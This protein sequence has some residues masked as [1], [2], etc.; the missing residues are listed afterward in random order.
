MPLVHDIV[1]P[2]APTMRV[3]SYRYLPK[4]FQTF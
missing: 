3:D 1:G 2:Y 4:S